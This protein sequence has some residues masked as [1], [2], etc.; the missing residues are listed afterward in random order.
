LLHGRCTLLQVFLDAA[1]N[2]TSADSNLSWQ[3][4]TYLTE[5]E[6]RNQAMLDAQGKPHQPFQLQN[7]TDILP[8]LSRDSFCVL[9]EPS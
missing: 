5:H 8:S 6:Q 1:D 2:Y 7:L 3:L 4:P 9:L